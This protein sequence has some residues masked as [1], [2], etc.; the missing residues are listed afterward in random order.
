MAREA[1]IELKCVC[2]QK[3]ISFL[4]DLLCNAGW[5]VFNDLGEIEYLPLG[6]D[7]DFCWQEEKKTYDELKEI[8]LLKQ[9]NDEFIGV[10]LFYSGTNQGISFLGRNIDDVV[11]SININ[12]KTIGEEI[13]S[14]TDF[15]WYF[16]RIIKVLHEEKSLSVSYKIEDFIG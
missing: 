13:D 9:Q 12:R 8:L 2:E 10:N 14:L 7:E 1:M 3:N 4:I 15:E 11:I 6:D 16:S 5:T